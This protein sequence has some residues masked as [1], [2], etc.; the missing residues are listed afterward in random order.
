ML[1]SRL[2]VSILRLEHLLQCEEGSRGL[3]GLIH[4]FTYNNVAEKV[5]GAPWTRTE[6]EWNSMEQKYEKGRGAMQ[7]S[8]NAIQMSSCHY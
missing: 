6:G 7:A 5:P 4:K 3:H 2:L 8:R 1:T